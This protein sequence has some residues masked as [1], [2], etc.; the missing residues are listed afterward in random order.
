MESMFDGDCQSQTSKVPLRRS[1]FK[2]TEG[3]QTRIPLDESLGVTG[4]SFSPDVR[5]FM[6]RAGSRSSLTTER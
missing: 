5:R 3:T 1:I 6:A 4:A 2:N